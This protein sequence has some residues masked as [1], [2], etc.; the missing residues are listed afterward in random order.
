MAK[1]LAK[2]PLQEICAESALIE[3]LGRDLARRPPVEILCRN[4]AKSLW[5]PCAESPTQEFCAA[6]STENLSRRSCAQ[7][8]AEIFAKGT[9]YPFFSPTRIALVLRACSHCWFGIILELLCRTLTTYCVGSLAGMIPIA[10]MV[11]LLYFISCRLYKNISP[12]KFPPSSS[13]N[14]ACMGTPAHP[15]L[16]AAG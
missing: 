7:F 13:A 1:C 10:N 16:P 15:A 8:S 14:T 5:T 3:I 9:W 2:R 4:L 12:R 11:L 6:A